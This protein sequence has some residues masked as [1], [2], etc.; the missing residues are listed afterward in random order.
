MNCRI[1]QDSAHASMM[2]IW[3]LQMQGSTAIPLI[4][5]WVTMHKQKA[6]SYQISLPSTCIQFLNTNII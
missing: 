5:K 4:C 1:D 2:P 3:A 6:A